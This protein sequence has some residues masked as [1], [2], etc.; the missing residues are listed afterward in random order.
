MQNF[1]TRRNLI[2]AVVVV[3]LAGGGIIWYFTR[4]EAEV[5]E[6]EERQGFFSR[7]FPGG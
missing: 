7:L 4:P 5:P 6:G 1:F 2:I 3:I